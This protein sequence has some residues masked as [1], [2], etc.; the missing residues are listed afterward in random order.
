MPHSSTGSSST[1][2]AG[3]VGGVLLTAGLLGTSAVAT[4]PTSNASCISV[5]GIGNSD[6]CQS[7]A[8]SIAIALGDS[9]FAV[10]G[11]MF[12]IAFANSLGVDSPDI[13][14]GGCSLNGP[15]W[16]DCT[17]SITGTPQPGTGGFLSLAYAGG[18]AASA[19]VTGNLSTALAQGD[20]AAALVYG[21][22]L[23]AAVTIGSSAGGAVAE[24]AYGYGNVAASV[25]S[26]SDV[27][28]QR[29]LARVNG[30]MSV[31][32]NL[33]T[34]DSVSNIGKY[35][36]E[37]DPDTA[38]SAAFNFRGRNNT[39]TATG[40]GA[41]AGTLDQ[42]GVTVSQEGPGTKIV[43]GKSAP[44]SRAAATSSRREA[45]PASAAAAVKARAAKS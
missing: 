34:V 44:A 21:D 38:F 18:R 33:N 2:V 5:F 19:L 28:G 17:A 24:V 3:A 11:G 45:K 14:A 29:P 9:A 1:G 32:V 13:P 35:L 4:A 31:A 20:R 41:I 40:V 30:R 36:L 27:P 15:G 39:V 37:V 8:T 26:G 22:Y 16:G 12:S 6:Q 42:A 23:N 25:F 10:A 43:A 7:S